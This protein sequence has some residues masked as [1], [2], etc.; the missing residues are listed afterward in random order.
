MYL[1]KTDNKERD[2]DATNIPLMSIANN[3][4]LNVFNSCLAAK[5]INLL[6]VGACFFSLLQ[7][8]TTF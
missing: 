1:I 5:S 2:E 4:R 8:L 6:H 7:F 3:G